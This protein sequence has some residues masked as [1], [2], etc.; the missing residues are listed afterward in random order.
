MASKTRIHL[1]VPDSHAHPD[2]SNERYDYLGHLINDL[3]HEADELTCIDIGDWWDMP[4]LCSYDRGLKSFEGR[5][6]KKDIEAGVEAQD[7]MMTI[8]RRQKKKLPRFVRCL[9]NHEDRINKAINKDPVLEGTVGTEDLMSKEY[10]WEEYS[11]REIVNVDG[12]DY[13]H[14]FV[15]GVKAQPI[16]G[17]RPGLALLQKRFKSSTM[18]HTHVLDHCI[19]SAGDRHI[20]G[21]VCGVY[22]DYDADYAGQAN[23]IWNRGVVI[24]RGVENGHYDLEWIS[25]ERLKEMYG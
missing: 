5:R 7:R 6:Y 14:Y 15:S 17:E 21:L 12:I 2:F 4:S 25:I 1:V 23:R 10:G 22:Q 3:R 20:H 24:K 11:F 18:G 13:S 19:R 8:V 16:G 9:G